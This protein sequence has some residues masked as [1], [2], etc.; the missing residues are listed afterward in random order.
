ML[1]LPPTQS[2]PTNVL[3]YTWYCHY[4]PTRGSTSD[5]LHLLPSLLHPFSLLAHVYF[6]VHF[7]SSF[8]SFN[9]DR[10]QLVT[11]FIIFAFLFS[12]PPSRNSD[13]GSHTRLFSPSSP[14]RFV[15]CIFIARRFQLFLPSSTRVQLNRA[16]PTLGALSTRSFLCLHKKS[17]F[18]HGGIRTHGPTLCRSTRSIR[19]LPQRV[20]IRNKK[21]RLL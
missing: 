15:P 17:K 14:L 6:H 18:H 5:A 4:A 2:A 7:L 20:Y 10:C 21:L 3:N 16:C 19:G 1:P 8:P 9:I 13:P 12:L 11:P